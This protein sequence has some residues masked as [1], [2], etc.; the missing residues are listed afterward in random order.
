MLF[1]T[2]NMVSDIVQLSSALGQRSRDTLRLA[3]FINIASW[4]VV[5]SIILLNS[6]YIF[7]SVVKPLFRLH[8]GIKIAAGDLDHKVAIE[9]Q[10]EI[11]DLSRTFDQMTDQLKDTTVSRDELIREVEERRRVEEE[12]RRN[13][14]WLE[15][16]LSSIGDA[17]IATDAFG[18]VTFLNPVGEELTGWRL[19]EALEQP[20][21][22]VFRIVDEKTSRPAE[23]IVQRVLREGCII[24]L[25]NHSSLVTRDGR[26]MPI[27][28]SAAPIRD[29]AGN[30]MAWQS[31][32]RYHRKAAG[33]RGAAGE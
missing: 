3:D 10:N 17:V 2:Q 30:L 29:D 13:R 28:D 26:E 1:E 15:V 33:R 20:I 19:E 12:L 5:L 27:E 31:I 23:N 25:A 11:G 22:N 18:L 7:T 9:V 21:Q 24:T 4:I 6:G 8:K 32:S 16:T 14:E